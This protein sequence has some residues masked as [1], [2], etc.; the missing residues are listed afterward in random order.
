MKASAK[1][2][3]PPPP[4]KTPGLRARAETRLRHLPKKQRLPAGA[5]DLDL[6][7]RRLLHELQVHHVEL[8]MQ[9]LELQEARD[10]VETLLEKYTDL[11]DFA[12][13]GYLSLDETGRILEVNLSGA[14][15]L[16]AARAELVNRRM[17]AFITP[18][19]QPIFQAFLRRVFSG[20]GKQVCEAIL[21]KADGSS[22]WADFHGNSALS[23]G[24]PQKW[25]R[26]VVSD[27]TAL[28]RAE[29]AQ[30]RL[31]A[32][33]TSNM[34]LRQEIARR[35]VVETSLKKSE[36]HQGRL[37]AQSHLMQE[38]LR[39]LSRQIISVQEE[40]RR[41]I[42]RELHDV[43]AQTLTGINVRL[44]ALAKAASVNTKDLNRDIAS[45]QRL[46]EKSVDI[47]HRF[48]RELRPAVL[49]DLGLIPALHSFV[50]TFSERTHLQI[51]LQAFAGVEQLDIAKR[52]VLFRVAQEAL[53]N[54]ARHAKASRVEV[55]LRKLP[56]GV[57][58]TVKDNGKSFQ[59]ERTLRANAGKR[60]GLL[61]MKERI[62]MVGGCLHI[63]SAPGQGTTLL[64]QVPFAITKPDKTD[65]SSAANRLIC[66]RL[67]CIRRLGEI[68]SL[69]PG[70]PQP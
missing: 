25:C 57:S 12:P 4:A 65:K 31:D 52:T 70:H 37:L 5:P 10:R 56:A 21:Q 22:F 69:K 32:L 3:R 67:S 64:V 26:V 66:H 18:A 39:Q 33:A 50:K 46:V 60:L 1:T 68:P 24:V 16:G 40:E 49:D 38:K 27:I 28:K 58:L 51:H 54:V 63:E 44:A 59:V 8:E 17:P 47:V 43:V 6:E 19:S 9:N 23:T 53:N 35:K 62:E 61:G 11:Y 55:N 34:A 7:P 20:A 45:T 30:R 15:L 2:T 48:A 41:E 29:E 13:V 36:Q 14:I 42:S